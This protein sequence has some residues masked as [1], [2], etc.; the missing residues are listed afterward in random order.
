[1]KLIQ[2]KLA[3]QKTKVSLFSLV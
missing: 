3:L 1:M 2:F